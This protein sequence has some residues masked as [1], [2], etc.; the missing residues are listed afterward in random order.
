MNFM[1]K[2]FF[3]I[4]FLFS[5]LSVMEAQETN[6]QKKSPIGSWKFEAPYAPQG[7]NNGSISVV[8]AENK[9]S[10]T[11]SFDSMQYQFPAEKVKAVADSLY[12][13]I[14][15]EGQSVDVSLKITDNSNMT[16]KAVYSE[17]SVPLI[18]KRTVEA[19]K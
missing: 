17:G 15:L 3:T 1:K 6:T 14:N 4:L 11:M 5:V 9:L 18:V 8:S 7:Y 12:F 19:V 16:G 10:A 2:I 13:S